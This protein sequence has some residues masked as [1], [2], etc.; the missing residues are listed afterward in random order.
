MAEREQALPIIR[1]K[2]SRGWVPL[3]LGDL[4]EYRELLFFLAWRD[5]QVRYKQAALGVSWAVLQPLLTVAI[6]S[7][8]FGRLAHLPSENIPYPVFTFA[9]LLPWQL[10]ATALQRSG[11]SLVNSS[12][13]LTKVYFPRLAIPVAATMMGIMDF[14]VSFVLLLIMMA[15][16]H[17]WPTLNILWLPLLTLLALV[18]SVA[19]GLWLSALNVRYRDVQQIIP[20]LAQIWMYASPVAYSAGLI[21]SSRWRVIY[22]LNPMAG[23]IEGFRWALL[24]S[25]PP[26]FLL[27]TSVAVTAVVL[28]SGL[29]YFRRMEA[30]FAD[31]V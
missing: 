30:T 21:A 22:F 12:A 11:T 4:W 10:F 15:Y 5:I 2:P 13:L 19:V 17:V 27:A 16:Y 20:F 25:E 3:H 28:V 29:Y 9:A 1:F 24:G 26:G 7:V 8:I 18:T 31:E 23:V 14:A 6:F